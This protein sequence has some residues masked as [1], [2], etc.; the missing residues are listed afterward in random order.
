MKKCKSQECIANDCSCTTKLKYVEVNEM[1]F[2]GIVI[3]IIGEIFI[4]IPA[5]FNKRKWLCRIGFLM[6]CIGSVIQITGA[7]MKYIN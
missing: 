5:F 3:V 2:I 4:L 6:F 1:I 7:I